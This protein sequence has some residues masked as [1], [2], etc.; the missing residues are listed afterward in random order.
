[1][2]IRKVSVLLSSGD[3]DEF[4]EPG[5]RYGARVEPGLGMALLVTQKNDKNEELLDS[6]Y[7]GGMWMK[8]DVVHDGS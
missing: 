5:V 3:I 8:F 4:E 7:A 1:M 6:M 2:A